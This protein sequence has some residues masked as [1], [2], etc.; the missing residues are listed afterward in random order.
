MPSFSLFLSFCTYISKILFQYFLV[1][2][3]S[4]DMRDATRSSIGITVA[5]APS[6]SPEIRHQP[7]RRVFTRPAAR[8]ARNNAQSFN[9]ET[10]GASARLDNT[11]TR[12]DSMK[13]ARCPSA[14]AAQHERI[15]R[16]GVTR[17]QA[18]TRASKMSGLD[19]GFWKRSNAFGMWRVDN[20]AP[21]PERR[22]AAKKPDVA[23]SSASKMDVG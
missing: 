22:S 15:V 13:M 4:V 16:G 2:F 18:L 23:P 7:S 14:C 3:S 10:A 12:S 8:R 19:I 17:K 11:D 6:H 5:K 1:S 9:R 20:H 21:I